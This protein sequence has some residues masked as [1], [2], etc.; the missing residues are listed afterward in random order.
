MCTSITRTEDTTGKLDLKAELSTR[1]Q[2]W[3]AELKPHHQAILELVD[4]E[5]HEMLEQEYKTY[6][7]YDNKVT[8]ITLRLQQLQD[9]S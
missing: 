2:L 9:L 6:N 7:E 8:M 5:Q 3:D 1:K 4:E